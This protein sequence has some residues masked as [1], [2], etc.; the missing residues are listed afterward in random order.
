MCRNDQR[1]AVRRALRDELGADDT[2]CTGPI[3]DHERLTGRL[4]ELPR[5]CAREYLGAIPR[6]AGND[7]P[8]PVSLGS[9]EPKH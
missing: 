4:G 2:A 6:R 1:V 9:S 3:L 7:H 5:H 8:A